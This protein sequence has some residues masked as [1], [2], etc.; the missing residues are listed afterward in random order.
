MFSENQIII[1]D[2]I[3]QDLSAFNYLNEQG[4]LYSVEIWDVSV[5][6]AAL[7]VIATEDI[8]STL[9]S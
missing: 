3:I 9:W 1:T 7:T 4:A 2:Y 8:T 6:A 5:M